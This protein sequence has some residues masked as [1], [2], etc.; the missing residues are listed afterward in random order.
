MDVLEKTENVVHGVNTNDRKK[1]MVVNW[2]CWSHDRA[3]ERFLIP[4]I[5]STFTPQSSVFS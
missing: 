1:N 5:L 2:I 3:C 4:Y